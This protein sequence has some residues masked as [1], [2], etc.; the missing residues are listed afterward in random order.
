MKTSSGIVAA[1][2]ITQAALAHKPDTVHKFTETCSMTC[3]QGDWTQNPTNQSWSCS[4]GKVEK[5]PGCPKAPGRVTL[6]TGVRASTFDARGLGVVPVQTK[7][8]TGR[9]RAKPPRD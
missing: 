6:E 4:S 9:A 1:L 3:L 5:D 8:E 2:L 7:S